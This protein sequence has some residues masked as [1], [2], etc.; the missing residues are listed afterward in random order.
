MLKISHGRRL[1]FLKKSLKI[2]THQFQIFPFGKRTNQKTL[3]KNLIQ[4]PNIKLGKTNKN[5]TPLWLK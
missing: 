5:T 3:Q 2:L 1:T 4:K